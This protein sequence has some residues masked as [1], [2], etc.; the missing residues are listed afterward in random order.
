MSSL[1]TLSQSIHDGHIYTIP[2][3]WIPNFLWKY[4][5][6]CHQFP[7]P[8]N[9]NSI[10]QGFRKTEWNNA[11]KMLPLVSAHRT[12]WILALLTPVA[13][14]W[15]DNHTHRHTHT[16]D[17]LNSGNLSFC[18]IDYWISSFLYSFK[19]IFYKTDLGSCTEHVLLNELSWEKRPITSTQVENWKSAS[20]PGVPPMCLS[21]PSPLPSHIIAAIPTNIV[22]P[23]LH[24]FLVYLSGIYP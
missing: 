20:H 14:K 7:H 21:E 2:D 5:N 15:A 4:H 16:N 9:N 8:E 6:D 17:N 11:C 13:N 22:I 12:W 18:D 19:K 23:F 3:S 1:V 10:S 24:F